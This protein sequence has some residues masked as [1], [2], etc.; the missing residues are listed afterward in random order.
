MIFGFSLGLFALTFINDQHRYTLDRLAGYSPFYN[1]E[2]EFATFLLTIAALALLLRKWW[3][4]LIAIVAGGRIFYMTGYLPL[5]IVAE[6]GP[7]AGPLW[8][9]TTWKNWL[10]WTLETQPQYIL[11]AVV[12]ITICLYAG[13][14]LLQQLIRSNRTR[15]NKAL[16]L[17]AR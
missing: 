3:S 9:L 16:Q 8:S 1:S 13:V 12:G 5:L 6:V 7:G 2:N 4:H 15:A 11:H 17:T 10:R 14:A